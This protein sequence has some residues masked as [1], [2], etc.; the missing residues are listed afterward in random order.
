MNQSVSSAAYGAV[1]PPMRGASSYHA[2]SL[3]EDGGTVGTWSWDLSSGE[4]AWS[5]GALQMLGLSHGGSRASFEDFL[6][7]VHPDDRQDEYA[8][9]ERLAHFGGTFDREVRLVRRGGALRYVRNRGEAILGPDGRPAFAIGAMSD[10]TA[11]REAEAA[12]RVAARRLEALSSAISGHMWASDRTGRILDSAGFRVV[13]G[14]EAIAGPFWFE[15]VHPLDRLR[16]ELAWT[17]AAEAGEPFTDV[18]RIRTDP[19]AE[20]WFR[21]S[22]QPVMGEAGGIAEWIGVLEPVA[23]PAREP[24]TSGVSAKAAP[25]GCQVRAARAILNWSVGDLAEKSGVSVSTIRRAEAVDGLSPTL[26]RDKLAALRDTLES[27][28]IELTAEAGR[29]PGVRPA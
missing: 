21:T 16:V 14:L 27:H 1:S 11:L 10:V 15:A 17:A 5:P 12:R 29:K 3:V 8:E 28:G 24:G 9:R 23:R 22:V 2:L 6:Q 7:I 26:R 18:H 20:A 19:R 4:I 25:T 13:G